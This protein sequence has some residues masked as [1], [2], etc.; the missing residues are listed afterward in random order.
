MRGRK[1]F[2]KP[3]KFGKLGIGASP[4]PPPP[5]TFGEAW[6]VGGKGVRGVL[7]DRLSRCNWVA[8]GLHQRFSVE[9]RFVRDAPP[10]FK[11]GTYCSTVPTP[12]K[13]LFRIYTIYRGVFFGAS[14]F[15]RFGRRGKTPNL[16]P[17]CLHTPCVTLSHQES[18]GASPVAIE[19][20]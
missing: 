5:C 3:G 4:L 13:K 6:T 2:T 7:Y 8:S 11:E 12:P 9:S 19:R 16:T 1:T 10:P 20:E 14:S 15:G 18:V 17:R